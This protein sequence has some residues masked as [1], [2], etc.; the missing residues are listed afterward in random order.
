MRALPSVQKATNSRLADTDDFDI[1]AF[2]RRDAGDATSQPKQKP[3]KV[4]QIVQKLIPIGKKK[5]ALDPSVVQI[6]AAF[7][8]AY[9]PGLTFRQVLR[10]VTSLPCAASLETLI[11]SVSDEAGSRLN[12]WA[13][14]MLAAHET[15]GRSKRLSN[16][17]LMLVLGQLRALDQAA[18][19]AIKDRLMTHTP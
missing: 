10:A 19:E 12:A 6:L 8:D 18:Q 3:T 16:D 13:L 17:A 5:D 14:Y 15:V 9:R 2:L 4:Q 11:D 7:N 1:P